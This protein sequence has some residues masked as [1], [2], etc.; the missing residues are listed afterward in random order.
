MN[1][2]TQIQLTRSPTKRLHRAVALAAIGDTA[3]TRTRIEEGM[4][5]NDNDNESQTVPTSS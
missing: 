1:N 2:T 5:H 3:H 4:G